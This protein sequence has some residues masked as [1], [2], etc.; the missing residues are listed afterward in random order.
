MQT[1]LRCEYGSRAMGTDTIF[2]D[3]D[4]MEV[5]VE[6]P[7][8]VTGLMGARSIKSSTSGENKASGAGDIDIIRH[9]LRKWADLAAKGN[10]SLLTPLFLNS[11][12]H[13][14]GFFLLLNKKAFISKRAGLQALGYISSQVDILT[15]VRKRRTNRPDLVRKYGWDTK[16]GYH[17]LRVGLQGI[18]LMETGHIELPIIEPT[19]S[20]L[21]DVREGKMSKDSALEWADSIAEDLRQAINKSDLPDSPDFD[22]I[23][24]ILHQIY[25]RV[26][27]GK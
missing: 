8:Y 24:R 2:S 15:G 7:E 11:A 17:M 23:N 4:I 9:P 13:F 26:W 18:E 3:G 5:F 10:P 16:F 14:E 25:T 20:L 21:M 22:M 6:S 19:R 27:M 12:V 1:I